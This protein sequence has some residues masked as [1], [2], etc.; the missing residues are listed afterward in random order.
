MSPALF[1]RRS[2]DGYVA[3]S[4][5]AASATDASDPRSSATISSAASGVSSRISSTAAP[6]LA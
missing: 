5:P 3:V 1:T 2:I 6:A 4:E